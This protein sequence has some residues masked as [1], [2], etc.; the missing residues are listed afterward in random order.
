MP[1]WRLTANAEDMDGC[2]GKRRATEALLRRVHI[3]Y[4]EKQAVTQ[5]EGL[6]DRVLRAVSPLR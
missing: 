4:H 2:T 6:H 1:G 5:D 3:A